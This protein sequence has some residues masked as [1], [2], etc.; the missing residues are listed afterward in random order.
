MADIVLL[1]ESAAATTR[2]YGTTRDWEDVF[3]RQDIGVE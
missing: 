1:V 3:R 2:S